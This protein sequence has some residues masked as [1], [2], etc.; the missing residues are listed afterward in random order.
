MD[1]EETAK[2][3]SYISRLYLLMMMKKLSLKYWLDWINA[4][5]SARKQRSKN[6]IYKQNEINTVSNKRLS[7][8]LNALSDFTSCLFF[9][10]LQLWSDLDFPPVKAFIFIADF[11]SGNQCEY[12]VD[13]WTLSPLPDANWRC[14][15]EKQAAC[16]LAA[17][18]CTLGQE[19]G[20]CC[21]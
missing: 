14:K 8:T 16:C 19:R 2:L 5:L 11:V 21:N 17:C 20:V 7:F 3:V 1:V 12:C 15:A 4:S 6:I 10:V 18:M 13:I 9:S